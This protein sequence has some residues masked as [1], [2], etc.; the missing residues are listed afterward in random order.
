MPEDSLITQVENLMSKAQDIF[1]E[2]EPI[3]K[4]KVPIIKFVEPEFQIKFDLS[5]NQEDGL[6][7]NM[8]I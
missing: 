7:N 3:K 4:T 1:S 2:I 8:E 6:R 5:F